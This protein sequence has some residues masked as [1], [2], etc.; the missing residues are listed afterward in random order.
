M[1]K[2][3]ILALQNCQKKFH[4]A[5]ESSDANHFKNAMDDFLPGETNAAARRLLQNAFGI[6]A[7]NLLK[8]PAEGNAE[9]EIAST[10]LTNWKKTAQKGNITAT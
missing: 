4:G 10:M 7:F 2:E 6:N 1:K 5:L 8:N 9:F 3:I